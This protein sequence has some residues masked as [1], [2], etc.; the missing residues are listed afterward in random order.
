M[1]LY[2]SP[3][4]AIKMS[5]FVLALI[6]TFLFQKRMAGAKGNNW[7]M[8]LAALASLILWFGVG[9]SGRAIAFF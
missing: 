7:R 6:S 9:I 4:F 2:N 3:P 1:K 5:F 8:K